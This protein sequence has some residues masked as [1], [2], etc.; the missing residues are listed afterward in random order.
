DERFSEMLARRMKVFDELAGSDAISADE[1][2]TLAA[3][4]GFPIE[5]TQELAG[6]RGQAV[7]VDG[8]RDLM[9][10]HR[11]ISR[12]GGETTTAQ[13]AAQLVGGGVPESEFVGYSRTEVLTAV[14]AAAPAEGSRQFVKLEQSPFYAASGGHVSDGGT[15]TVDDEAQRLNAAAVL[16]FG[17][18][19]VLMIDLVGH[20]PLTE[21]IRVEAVV[22]WRD[23]FP[24]QTNHTATHL[25]HQALRDVLGDHVKQAGSAVRPDKLRFDFTHD[26]Q[27]SQEERDRVEP[28][29]NDKVFD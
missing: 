28:I 20:E 4:F 10:R 16:K 21:G 5:L 17:D 2:F 29:G 13:A 8:F 23:R 12:A 26:R 24:T 3:T 1:A 25:L 6:E 19:Q 15:V 14:I 11:E 9:A 18:D 7:D 22:S 27:L